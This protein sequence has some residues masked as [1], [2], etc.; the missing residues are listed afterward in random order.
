MAQQ[1]H[2]KRFIRNRQRQD[3]EIV[4]LGGQ[5]SGLAGGNRL[6]RDIQTQA[7]RPAKLQVVTL[8]AAEIADLSIAQLV[9]N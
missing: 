9:G 3:V 6:C 8:I 7:S 4:A 1:H 5:T 2:L